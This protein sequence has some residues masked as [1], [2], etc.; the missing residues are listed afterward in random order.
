LFILIIPFVS[1]HLNKLNT[2][3]RYFKSVF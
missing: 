2:V 1:A 3:K